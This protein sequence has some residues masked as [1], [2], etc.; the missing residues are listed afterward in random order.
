MKTLPLG[1]AGLGARSAS[2]SDP[3]DSDGSHDFSAMLQAPPAQR[4]PLPT[5]P[6]APLAAPRQDHAGSAP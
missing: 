5:R 4:Q 2:G 6:R 1:L 3:G